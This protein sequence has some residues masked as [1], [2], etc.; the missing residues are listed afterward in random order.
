MPKAHLQPGLAH[1][2]D[3]VLLTPPEIGKRAL[4]YALSLACEA[5]NILNVDLGR[6]AILAMPRAWVLANIEV[7]MDAILVPDDAWPW[8]R[9]L[10]LAW[11][12]DLAL[13][14]RVALMGVSCA[15]AEIRSVCAEALEDLCPP[16]G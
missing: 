15:D 10:E 1:D 6:A 2:I 16:A 5:Q 7:A 12:L 13:F 8:R 14:R 3:A 9:S 4:S 11:K